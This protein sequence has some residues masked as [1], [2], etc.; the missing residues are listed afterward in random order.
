MTCR[1]N[2][3]G[4]L[5]F[6]SKEE[7]FHWRKHACLF[8]LF[9]CEILTD[10]CTGSAI[11][12]K[13]GR[14]HEVNYKIPCQTMQPMQQLSSSKIIVIFKQWFVGKSLSCSQNVFYFRRDTKHRKKEMIIK[15]LQVDKDIHKFIRW[16][17]ITRKKNY[18]LVA[19]K[20]L[21]SNW[22][23][24][25]LVP[26]QNRDIILSNKYTQW[27]WLSHIWSLL[28]CFRLYFLSKSPQIAYNFQIA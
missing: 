21:S 3:H 11:S 8:S 15:S 24:F 7:N 27:N 12:W 2:F 17:N 28:N 13:W 6:T 5:L 14:K 10:G 25:V 20:E 22:V 26:F 9:P 4:K 1:L 16:K 23:I 19:N 18:F